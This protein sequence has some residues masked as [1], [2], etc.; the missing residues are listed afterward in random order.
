MA[1]PI[2]FIA[3]EMMS[4]RRIPVTKRN[5]PTK[6]AITLMLSRTLL[7]ESFFSPL[8]RVRPWVQTKKVCTAT[9]AEQYMI[10]FSPNTAATNGMMRFPEFE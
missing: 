6:T 7:S 2:D 5:I 8:T 1:S 4:G 10:S 3:E 9:N